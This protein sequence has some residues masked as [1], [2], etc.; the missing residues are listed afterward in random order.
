LIAMAIGFEALFSPSDQA[1]LNFRICQTAAQFL[2]QNPVERQQIFSGL[3]KMYKR[4]SE[5]VHGTYDLEKC[6]SGLFVTAEEL[7]VWDEYLRRAVAGFLA[8]YLPGKRDAE[9]D[10]VLARITEINFDDS[11]RAKLREESDLDKVLRQ[12]T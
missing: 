9:R 5:I 7:D 3:K 6:L 10:P 1:E 12:T 2:G 4:R 8:L 11:K